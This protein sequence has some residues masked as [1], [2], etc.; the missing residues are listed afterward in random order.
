MQKIAFYLL[1]ILG[2]SLVTLGMPYPSGNGNNVDRTPRLNNPSVTQGQP[3]PPDGN[4]VDRTPR[5][6]NPRVTQ[7]QP[8]SPVS[9]EIVGTQRND[10][11]INIGPGNEEEH[12]VPIKRGSGPR[13]CITFCNVVKVAGSCCC[14]LPNE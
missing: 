4:N 11:I 8:I 3:I 10:E 12:L 1:A 9:L 7:G 5:L 2:T 6:N 13:C 14:K